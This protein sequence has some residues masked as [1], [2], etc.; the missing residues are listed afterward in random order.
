MCH[1]RGRSLWFFGCRRFCFLS[2]AGQSLFSFPSFSA[3][4]RSLSVFL[5]L[6]TPCPP[7]PLGTMSARELRALDPALILSDMLRPVP[8]RR[9]RLKVSYLFRQQ[10]HG[11]LPHILSY[12]HTEISGLQL[13]EGVEATPL[14]RPSRH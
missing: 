5:F 4:G 14:A 9:G 11:V 8:P 10:F 6:F 2:T 7:G 3:A 1:Q 12:I 13:G